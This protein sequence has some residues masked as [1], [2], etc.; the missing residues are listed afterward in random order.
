M[1]L[2]VSIIVLKNIWNLLFEKGESTGQSTE[3]KE[4][5]NEVN[6][7]K[8]QLKSLKVSFH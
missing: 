4:M 8:K 5:T 7:L 1:T 2:L 3:S 6:E